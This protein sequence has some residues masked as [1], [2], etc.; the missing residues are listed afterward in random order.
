MAKKETKSGNMAKKGVD[1]KIL[2]HDVLRRI[3]LE[4]IKPDSEIEVRGKRL[5]PVL[6]A[7]VLAL[8]SG[9]VIYS[10]LRM[11]TFYGS[12]GSSESGGLLWSLLL[13]LMTFVGIGLCVLAISRSD[14]GYRHRVGGIAAVVVAVVLAFSTVLMQGPIE[15]FID[16]IGLGSKIRLEERMLDE[17]S[18]YGLVTSVSERDFRIEL[19][20]GG[21][22]RV[23]VDGQTRVYPNS[24]RIRQGQVVAV[25]MKEDSVARW[26]RILPANHP[27][28]RRQ[29][30]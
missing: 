3:Q 27:A 2:E 7:G 8:F 9:L 11:I 29:T 19:M 13:L 23:K 6:A 20:G 12:F 30:E 15:R 22:V 1:T 4:K 16:S 14:W 21:S 5:I 25:L 10:V 17:S 18:V 24:S 28:G 26:V